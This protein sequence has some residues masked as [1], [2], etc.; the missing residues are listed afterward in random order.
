MMYAVKKSMV[1]INN[2][3]SSGT[4]NDQNVVQATAI[5]IY[6]VDIYMN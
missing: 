3:Y 5:Y 1:Y 4:Q 6:Y 2:K